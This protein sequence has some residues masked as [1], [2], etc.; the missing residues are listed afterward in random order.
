ML[1]FGAVTEAVLF[2][3]LVIVV[4]F[5]FEFEPLFIAMATAWDAIFIYRWLLKHVHEPALLECEHHPR[6]AWGP[7]TLLYV[8]G[9]GQ[10][11]REGRSLMWLWR[12]HVPKHFVAVSPPRKWRPCCNLGDDEYV[13]AVVAA[14]EGEVALGRTVGIVG[15][16]RGA[17]VALEAVWRIIDKDTHKGVHSVVL[18][19]G[20]FRTVWNVLQHRYGS[21]AATALFPL[22]KPFCWPHAI[23]LQKLRHGDPLAKRTLFVTSFEDDN[24]PAADV[25]EHARS[26]KA[27]WQTFQDAPHDMIWASLDTKR[28][29]QAFIAQALGRAD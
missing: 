7:D 12:G 4:I 27:Q 11:A 29:L 6:D 26:K 3:I 8:P 2:N 10:P 19:N 13:D 1:G 14:V 25:I 28:R 5:L 24:L 23:P 18:L 20:P 16:S 17:G 21:W 22:V 15:M 9:L